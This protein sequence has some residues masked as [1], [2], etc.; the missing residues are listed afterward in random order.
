[1]G[2]GLIDIKPLTLLLAAICLVFVSGC[3]NHLLETTASPS[4]PP[5]SN[6]QKPVEV[7]Q[8]DTL[9]ISKTVG[10]SHW[11]IY[12]KNR[13][14]YV[15]YSD[16]KG[17]HR[18][19]TLP[20]QDDWEKDIASSDCVLSGFNEKG[21]SWIL[22]HSDMASGSQKKDLFITNDN[23]QTWKYAGAMPS[24]GY[25]NGITFRDESEGWAGFEYYG[26][27]LIPLYHSIDGGKT[28]VKQIIDLPKGY[29]YGNVYAPEF[30]KNSNLMGKIEIEFARENSDI[31]DI[32]TY[33]T[34]DGGNTW[35][36]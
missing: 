31:K 30:D 2:R 3:D 27:Y 34:D 29:R 13:A 18:S 19:N 15:D 17:N 20:L 10:S 1:M 11:G 7:H 28:W 25:V 14:I 23:G 8:D 5:S 9:I 12:Q 22:L 6:R 35:S 4:S 24:I 32:I 16:D 26:D 21:L 33:H 36:K